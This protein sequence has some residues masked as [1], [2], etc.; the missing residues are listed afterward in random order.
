MEFTQY[1]FAHDE[2]HNTSHEL[3]KWLWS[4]NGNAYRRQ[5]VSFGP[6][7]S[8]RQDHYGRPFRSEDATFV[9]HSVR[10]KTSTTY[11]Q[12]LFPSPEF[13]FSSPGTKAEATFLCTELDKLAWLG[14]GGY[15]FFGLWIHGVQYEKKDGSKLFGSFLPVLFESASDPITT[16][17]EELG[18]PKLFCDIEVTKDAKTSRIVCGWRGTTFVDIE[19]EGL[20]EETPD[21]ATNGSD[22]GDDHPFSNVQSGRGSIPSP[23]PDSGLLVYR[24]VP[25]VGNRGAADAEYP[26]F[27]SNEKSTVSLAVKKTMRSTDA[28]IDIQGRSWE[29]LPTI[30]HVALGL[31]E[32]PVYEVIEAKRE[33]GRG[34]EDLSH[35]ERIE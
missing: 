2:W 20:R 34:V 31:S 12:T 32:M 7:V 17:R 9:T 5:P 35:A 28:R 18:M 24:Y 13:S 10:F 21:N 33:E 25:A 27:L 11:L 16:G 3:K 30:H 1:N 29:S 19:L 15:N 26:V 8:P 14:G 6:M 23:P 22:K 4:R